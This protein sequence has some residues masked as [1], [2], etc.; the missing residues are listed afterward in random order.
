MTPSEEIKSRLDV[1]EV[2]REYIQLKAVGVNFQAKC[3]FHR[4]KTPSFIVSPE[5]QIWHCFGCSR[6]GDV[7]TFVMEMEGLSFVEA[8]R[9]LAQK[10]GVQLVRQDMQEVSKRNRLMDALELAVN[11]Y[12]KL[13][14][15]SAEAKSVREYLHNRGL[16]DETIQDFKIGY[17]K[18]SWDDLINLLKSKGYN[19]QE[20]L[21]AGLSVKKEQGSNY[22][23]RFRGRI[24]FPIN[25]YNGNTVAFSARVNPAKEETEKMG[26]YINSP[27]TPI[28]DKS[29]ILFGLDKAK[30][31]IRAE[32][33][34]IIV[35]GQMDVISS[36]Q[37]EVKNVVASSGTALTAD[38]VKMLKRYTNNLLLSFDVDVPGQI[39]AERGIEQA[40]A[41][42]VNIKIIEV[43]GG[44]DPDECIRGNV[45]N[46]KEAIDKA[47]GVMDYYFD[48]T[49]TGLD[50]SDVV[51]KKKAAAKL[52]NVIIKIGNPI[53]Q[54]VWLRKL[55]EKLEVSEVV[56]R[57]AITKHSGRPRTRRAPESDSS[58]VAQTKE[59][60]VTH[61]QLL[62]EALLALL[63]RF[64]SNLEHV[65]EKVNPDILAGHLPRIFYKKLII[66]YNNI[67]GN[68]GNFDYQDFKLWLQN[69]IEDEQELVGLRELLDK[70][71]LLADKEFY[72]FD[73][74]SAKR[75]LN[76][77]S[78]QLKKNYLTKKMLGIE[79]KL[80]E[81][82]EGGNGKMVKELIEEFRGLVKEMK[83][84]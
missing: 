61:Q 82:E 14:L 17:S 10:A 58:A 28:Y 13:L 77:I 39:A 26:K 72:N 34:V 8:L 60:T 56:L 15:E 63:I 73:E 45:E 49:F 46:W 32:D 22:Y 51:N 65:I 36:H 62:T 55:S 37:A 31:F 1:V 41:Q 80:A 68:T 76:R 33:K 44:K 75:E 30:S 35:E 42:D 57:E 70:L 6:G 79:R 11:Y 5:K 18:N 4:E 59:E 25:D 23:D 21:L 69:N 7:F 27:Q 29:K 71:V 12:H 53:E 47:K 16:K 20:V 54:D 43:P 81:A 83:E 50:L 24:M 38:Q 64:F 3:P 66:Y 19:E 52:L 48:K 40:L 67:S 84:V 2:V 9:M 74:I 78:N